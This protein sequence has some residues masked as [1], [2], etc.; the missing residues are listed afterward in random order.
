MTTLASVPAPGKKRIK[1]E[2]VDKSPAEVVSDEDETLSFPPPP[3]RMRVHRLSYG[4][5]E[6]EPAKL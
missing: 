5:V 2:V 6:S 1:P 3:R 4:P